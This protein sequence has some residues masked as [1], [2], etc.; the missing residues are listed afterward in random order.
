MKTYVV[1][2]LKDTQK[3]ATIEKQLAVH[4]E[5]DYQIWKA[6]EGRKLAQEELKD[7]VSPLFYQRYKK[8][9]SL[10]ALGCALSHIS[11]YRDIVQNNIPYALILEDDA[12]LS[13]N[14]CLDK[15]VPL[16]NTDKPIAILL[17][18]DFWYKKDALVKE[19]SE[20]HQVF[21]LYDGYMTS[22][23]LV[24]KACAELLQ[25][26][27]YPVQ[28]TADAWKDFIDLGVTLYGVVPHVISFPDGMGEIGQSGYIPQ[29]LF[30]KMK[31][32]IAWMY[33]R[34]LWMG[35]Y[36][37]GHRMSKKRWC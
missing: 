29:T 1:N 22:G 33:I 26:K 11:I 9:A 25:K 13:Q 37:K 36:L 8:Y 31:A 23:Y 35:K 14:L 20:N 34:M 32:K 5:L 17:T 6:V 19:I 18:S 3:R 28:F 21:Q 10:P 4:P 24:N 27:I 7:C 15:L 16:L 2:M 30:Q 12:I